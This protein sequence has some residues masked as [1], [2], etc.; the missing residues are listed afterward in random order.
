MVEHKGRD[1]KI[2][3]YEPGKHWVI[4]VFDESKKNGRNIAIYSSKN[5]KEWTLESNLPGYFECPE[6]FE[7]P[8]D[9][10]P[11]NKK[12]VIFAADAQYAIGNFNG[13]KFTPDHEGKNRVHWGAYYASQCF[14]QPPDGRVVQICW[15]RFDIPNMPFN[16]TFSVPANLTLR[17]TK[18]G[19]RLFANPIKEIEQLRLPNPQTIA[20]MQLT[21]KVPSVTLNTAGQLCD[22]LVTLR[23]GTASK[24]ILQ[25]GENT[26]TY[27]FASQKLDEMP[28]PMKNDT[29]S[30]RVL[31][32]RPMFELFGGDGACCKTSGR[33]DMGK[34]L[35]TISLSAEGG[36]LSVESLKVFTLSSAW[37]NIDSTSVS[38]T[39]ETKQ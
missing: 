3:W 31:V 34:P 21:P 38:T 10:N 15:A 30:F 35:G 20:N 17:T 36:S 14:S 27:D 2:I 37:K 16:Q 28:L 8:V 22:I 39:T 18:D 26:A 32:D 13:K 33:R 25:F 12:W 23:R 6:L 29:V 7:L 5:L 24:A 19:I 4:A 11:K 9:G 1:P